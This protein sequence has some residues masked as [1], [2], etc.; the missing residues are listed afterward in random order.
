MP[1]YNPADGFLGR[2]QDRTDFKVVGRR[3]VPARMSYPIA[4]G[5]AKYARDVVLPDMLFGKTLRSPYA[6]AK[7]KSIDTSRAEALPG[8][9]AVVKWDDPEIKDMGLIYGFFTNA[10]YP[11]GAPVLDNQADR[12]GEEVGVAVAAESEEICDEA[13]KQVKVEWEVLPHIIDI[14]DA[15]K[16]GA[17]ILQP[18]VFKDTNV[19]WKESW[20]DGDVEAGFKQ[21]DHVIEYDLSYPFMNLH[22]PNP[23]TAV[24]WWAQD[25]TGSEGKTLYLQGYGGA[26]TAPW[27]WQN[28][29]LDEDKVR[30]LTTTSGGQY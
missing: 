2:N 15:I 17:P 20:Q 22:H 16:P 30:F 5:V 6:R 7:I 13:L 24:A 27:I 11:T 3:D 14:K 12:E 18:E 23:V 28:L 8:V 4:T 25:P 19:A 26:F 21:A 9:K 29:K 1:L 10:P